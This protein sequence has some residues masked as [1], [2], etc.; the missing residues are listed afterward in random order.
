MFLSLDFTQATIVPV[1]LSHSRRKQSRRRRPVAR[2]CNPACGG[3]SSTTDVGTAEALVS[4]RLHPPRRRRSRVVPERGEPLAHR[5]PSCPDAG[6]QE[7]SCPSMGVPVRLVDRALDPVE[8]RLT[9]MS[10][11]SVAC[12]LARW[13]HAIQAK[14]YVGRTGSGEGERAGAGGAHLVRHQGRRLV[15]PGQGRPRCGRPEREEVLARPSDP[16]PAACRQQEQVA[17]WPAGGT[18][19][20]RRGQDRA[21]TSAGASGIN[22]GEST[23]KPAVG[24]QE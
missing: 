23:R 3:I 14:P 17:G 5:V 10:A 19:R 9:R 13:T 24:R 11:P 21:V 8:G 15:R 20:W 6:A 1:T 12:R 18:E 16:R 7:A 2:S 22:P 4:G